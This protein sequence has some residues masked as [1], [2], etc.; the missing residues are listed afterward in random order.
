MRPESTSLPASPSLGEEF[1]RLLAFLR[2]PELPRAPSG[3]RRAAFVAVMR[4]L[5]VDLAAMILLISLAMLIIAAGFEMPESDLAGVEFSFVVVLALVLGAPLGEEIIFRG[6]L[7]GR[8]AHAGAV[9]ALLAGLALA[10]TAA[11]ADQGLLAVTALG[12]GLLLSLVL[13]LTLRQ[14]DAP[15]WFARLFPLFFWLSTLGFAFV[16]V[17]N[18]SGEAM[19][20]ALPLVAPQFV[21]G[22]ILGYTRVSYGLWA[23]ILLHALH[24]GAAVGAVLVGIAAG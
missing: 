14:R 9:F 17:F 12:G 8:P 10:L 1:R 21:T 24:N 6:W 11:S 3:P 13:W 18:F 22:A 16:H 5:V 19:L 23:S 15:R 2:R 7:S 20:L 4:L